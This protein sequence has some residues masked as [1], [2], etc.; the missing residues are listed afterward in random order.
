METKETTLVVGAGE[1]RVLF[2]LTERTLAAEVTPEHWARI[3]EQIRK[4]IDDGTLIGGVAGMGASRM[5]RKL[6]RWYLGPHDLAVVEMAFDGEALC[7]RRHGLGDA[8]SDRPIPRNAWYARFDAVGG[9]WSEGFDPEEARA[10]AERFRVLREMR[11]RSLG[12]AA[13]EGA[14]VLAGTA[15]VGA[16]VAAVAWTMRGPK[17]PGS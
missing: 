1:E 7:V 5:V 10:F 4:G 13:G 6:Q 16:L 14:K 12:Y 11:L 17:K 9:C 15:A 2:R 3:E 8:F